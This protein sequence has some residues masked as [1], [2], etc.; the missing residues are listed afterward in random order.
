MIHTTPTA[1][2]DLVIPINGEQPQGDEE[3][4]QPFEGV[5]LDAHQP[6]EIGVA[7]DRRRGDVVPASTLADAQAHPDVEQQGQQADDGRR[8]ERSVPSRAP[9][10]RFDEPARLA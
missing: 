5:G 10:F 8:L 3:D 2:G 7:G 4:R 6:L 9:P 1:G